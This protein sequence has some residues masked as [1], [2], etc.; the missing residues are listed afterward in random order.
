M[1]SVAD[2][3]PGAVALPR[4]TPPRSAAARGWWPGR[5]GPGR[6]VGGLPSVVRTP[7]GAARSDGAR[8]T[9][10]PPGAPPPASRADGPPVAHAR[11]RVRRLGARPGL[12]PS[13]AP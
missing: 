10:A 3:E 5:A 6:R 1:A 4:S 12:D 9:A 8:A 7:H 13:E 2:R 11:P